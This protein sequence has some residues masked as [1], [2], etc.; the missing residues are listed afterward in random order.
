MDVFM[1]TDKLCSYE[2]IYEHCAAFVILMT[3][4]TALLA[5]YL[6]IWNVDEQLDNM[7]IS[8]PEHSYQYDN[9]FMSSVVSYK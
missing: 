2:Y 9:A 8:V 5:E 1:N 6:Q 7:H 3:Y 4:G